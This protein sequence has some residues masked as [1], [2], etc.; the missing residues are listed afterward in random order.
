MRATTDPHA[1]VRQLVGIRQGRGIS[2]REVARRMGTVQSA[3]SDL[4][5]GANATLGVLMRYL[6]AIEADVI[7]RPRKVRKAAAAG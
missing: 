1:F 6:D 7:A 4:E 5:T 2:Q 3:V